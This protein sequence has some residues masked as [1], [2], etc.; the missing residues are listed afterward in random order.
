MILT[1]EQKKILNGEYGKGKAMAMQVLVG[2]AKCFDAPRLVPIS[3]AH[4]SMSAQEGD[5]W[6]ATKLWKAGA[7]C[8]VTPTVNPGYS[9]DYFKGKIS[10]EAVDN[11]QRTKQAYEGLGAR[12]TY[13]CT[14]Y[15]A[16]NIPQYHEIISFSETN[17][18]IYANAVQ[19]AYT[20]RESSASALCAAVTGYVP[21][22]GMLLEENRYATVAVDV[23]AKLRSDFDYSVLGLL[24]KKIGGGVPVFY[25]L[26]EKIS[27][28]AL[29][30]LGTVLNVSSN[31]DTFHIPNVTAE[32]VH[33][34]N[35]YAER[36]Q[37]EVIVTQ[38]DLDAALEAF[39]PADEKE[40]SY[41]VFGCPHYTYDQVAE[42]LRLFDG[43]PSRVPVYVLTSGRVVLQARK[44]GVEEQ[45]KALGVDLIPDTCVDEYYCWGHLADRFGVSDSLKGYYYMQV[46]GLHMAVRDTKTCVRALQEGVV[47]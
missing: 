4:I 11:M 12:M 47:R 25:G 7:T 29:I 24:G 3:K 42:M 21:E 20:N 22:Y 44:N 14:P 28:E 37:R 32:M 36:V 19:G 13:C 2:M 10:D 33:E 23:R 27:T 43:K 18:T 35:K 40:I 9:L 31:Y 15:L 26:P 1:E 39:S 17:A 41:G 34:H 8:A 46:S 30:G 6:F 5:T 45:L 16:D 38:D